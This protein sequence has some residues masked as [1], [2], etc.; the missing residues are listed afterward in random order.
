MSY[1]LYVG[2]NHTS[3]G[4][5]YLAGYGDE[6]SSHWLEVVPAADHAPGTVVTV[7]VTPQADLPGVLCDIP[8]VARTA[9]HLRVSYSYYR[10]V[11]APLTNGG[12]NEYGVAVRDVWSSSRPE[13]VAMT[14]PTQS[15]PNYLDSLLDVG[16][17]RLKNGLPGRRRGGAAVNRLV[18]RPQCPGIRQRVVGDAVGT[19]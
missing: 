3:D 8:Q 18:T 15:G 12:L 1:A 13:L 10:G 5:A 4:I 6:P 7:G 16:T 17:R 19:C 9:R 11:P 14:P 2:R